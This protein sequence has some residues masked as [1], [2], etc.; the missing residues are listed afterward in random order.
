M[1]AKVLLPLILVIVVFVSAA[2][3]VNMSIRAH[4]RSESYNSMQS[5]SIERLGWSYRNVSYNKTAVLEQVGKVAQCTTTFVDSAAPIASNT[6][7]T[8]LDV[9]AINSANERLQSN[10]SSGASVQVIRDDIR[11]FDSAQAS[12][13]WQ[14]AAAAHNLNQIQLHSIGTELSSSV[15]ILKSCVSS[16]T[17]GRLHLPGLGFGFLHWFARFGFQPPRFNLGRFHG[18]R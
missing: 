2:G 10:I 1:N 12:L 9:T 14:A 11:S 7:K 4:D 18:R 8:N 17:N 3:A 5:S 13:F 15:Q 16:N 6:L